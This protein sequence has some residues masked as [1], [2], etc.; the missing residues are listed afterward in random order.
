[1]KEKLD[2]KIKEFLN[3]L[4]RFDE[5][6]EP[7]N[8]I[9]RDALIKRFEFTFD[10]GWKSLKNFL[11]VEYS[12]QEIQ[13]PIQAFKA[14]FLVSVFNE[15][16]VQKWTKMRDTRNQTAHEYEVQIAEE[17]AV[18]AKSMSETFHNLS[19]LFIK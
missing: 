9:E 7:K 19:K 16:D 5:V 17:V 13:S 14:A 2:K 4:D 18:L 8:A 3:A 12:Q 15:D 1:M 6:L 10:T 11:E